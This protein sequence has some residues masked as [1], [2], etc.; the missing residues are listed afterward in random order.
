MADTT[1]SAAVETSTTATPRTV[2]SSVVPQTS[3]PT[4]VTSVIPSATQSIVS[5]LPSTG[6][7]YLRPIDASNYG[8][9]IIVVALLTMI[10]ELT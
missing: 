9:H 3:V 2:P 4:Q 10:L 7:A 8:T 6:S 1:R 5:A